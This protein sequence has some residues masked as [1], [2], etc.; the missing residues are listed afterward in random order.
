MRVVRRGRTDHLRVKVTHG[1]VTRLVRYFTIGP[2]Q[3]VS[4]QTWCRV[5]PIYCHYVRSLLRGFIGGLHRWFFLRVVRLLHDIGLATDQR[6][7]FGI[8]EIVLSVLRARVRHRLRLRRQEMTVQE[9]QLIRLV[10]HDS[11][12]QGR[13]VTAAIRLLR[14][15]LIYVSVARYVVRRALRQTPLVCDAV[16]RIVCNSNL[17]SIVIS[18]YSV[19]LVKSNASRRRGRGRRQRTLICF[20]F[21]DVAVLPTCAFRFCS[22]ICIPEVLIQ[23]RRLFNILCSTSTPYMSIPS[24]PPRSGTILPRV[25]RCPSARAL[26]CPF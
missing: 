19:G 22:E 15:D 4:R 18:E 16:K 25:L 9:C 21:R 5:L 10:V 11:F 13:G 23:R 20:F 17:S 2:V 14:F 7:A 12:S 1:G 6:L 26:R 3:V 24:L 8:F